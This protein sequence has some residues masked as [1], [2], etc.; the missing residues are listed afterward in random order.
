MSEPIKAVVVKSGLAMLCTEMRELF[1]RCY[2]DPKFDVDS[3]VLCDWLATELDSPANWIK[4]FVA[5]DEQGKLCG[6]SLVVLSVDPL[7][8]YPWINHFVAE[9]RGARDPLVEAT[10]GCIR[11]RGFTK[12]SLYNMTGASDEAHLRV[13]RKHATGRVRC[14]VIDYEMEN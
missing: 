5:Q 13:F 4:L 12:L 11:A 3:E 9:K 8:P 1:A 2:A 14:S 10:L 7:S 6:M